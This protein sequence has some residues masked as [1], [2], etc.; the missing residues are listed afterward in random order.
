[1]HTRLGPGRGKVFDQVKLWSGFVAEEDT[2]LCWRQVAL[3]FVPEASWRVTVLGS[4]LG[5]DVIGSI[6]VED[7]LTSKQRFELV[8]K[9]VRILD[10]SGEYFQ[11]A[12]GEIYLCT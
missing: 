12:E 3:K 6:K 1:M 7:Q 5:K 9:N 10:D 8:K 2:S 4:D 11:S